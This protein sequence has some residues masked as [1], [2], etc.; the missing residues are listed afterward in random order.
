VFGISIPV[1]IRVGE[2]T[3][4][5]EFSNLSLDRPKDLAPVLN[6]TINRTGN[7]SVYGDINVDFIS[8]EGKVTRVATV[9]GLAVYTP[10][11]KRQHH[12]ELN[13]IPGIDYHSGKL[14]IT[15][16]KQAEEKSLKIAEGDLL[17]N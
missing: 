3:T 14:H 13:K 2:N 9:N 4:K 5:V 15:F 7:M 12:M 6:M 17:L 11:L 8:P 1:I 16:S 10:T